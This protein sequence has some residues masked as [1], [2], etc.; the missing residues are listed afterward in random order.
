GQEYGTTLSGEPAPAY[1]TADIGGSYEL[2]R[3]ITLKAAV[4]NLADKR[5]D[6]DTYGT[7]NYGRTF[8]MGT[9][10]RF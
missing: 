2:T 6:D 7:V 10:L 4:Y 8:W 3:D 5:L 9:T 1:T